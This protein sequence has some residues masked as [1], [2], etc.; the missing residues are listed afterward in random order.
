MRPKDEHLG[1]I[2]AATG[3]SFDLLLPLFLRTKII[4]AMVTSMVNLYTVSLTKLMKLAQSITYMGLL[5][6]EVT[7]C[8]YKVQVSF[9][10]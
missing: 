8:K 6:T 10:H 2:T 4:K 1:D 7:R 9:D 3:I 5:K